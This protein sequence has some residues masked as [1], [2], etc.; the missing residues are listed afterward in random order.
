MSILRL[1]FLCVA[2]CAAVASVN[3]NDE[4]IPEAD[5]CDQ[6][7]GF[8]VEGIEI[9][10]PD[11]DAA[12][13]DHEVREIIS[14]SQGGTMVRMRFRID[15]AQAPS[16]VRLV[17]EYENCLDLACT[18]VDPNESLP[19][20]VSLRTYEDGASRITREYF[21]VLD[22]PLYRGNL[23]RVTA[24]VAPDTTAVPK[25]ASVLIWLDYEGELEPIPVDAG[26]D[27]F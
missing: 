25:T 24:T 27:A 11:G 16:C 13:Q 8:G 22:Y 7:V 20:G 3:P 21:A 23:M 5:R 19:L 12:L 26:P 10:Q 17:L 14:G 6:G 1:G 15:G 18:R 2:L 4:P 9:V